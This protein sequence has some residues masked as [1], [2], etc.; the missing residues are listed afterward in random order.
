VAAERYNDH[1]VMCMEMF[2]YVTMESET[3][4]QASRALRHRWARHIKNSKRQ[5]IGFAE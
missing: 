1:V 4:S 2:V 5:H 3:T